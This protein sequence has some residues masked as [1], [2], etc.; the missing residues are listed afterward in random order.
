MILIIHLSYRL[1]CETVFKAL[2]SWYIEVLQVKLVRCEKLL[3]YFYKILINDI[4]IYLYMNYRVI[5]ENKR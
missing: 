1:R 5:T 2:S 4:D 3:K